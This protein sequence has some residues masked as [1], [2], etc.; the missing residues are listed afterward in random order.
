MNQYKKSVGESVNS[1]ILDLATVSGMQA[2]EFG[3][4]E[5]KLQNY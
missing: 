5:P 1:K 2:L 4:I 3:Q